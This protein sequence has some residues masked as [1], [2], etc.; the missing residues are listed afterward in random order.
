M[1]RK[2]VH[3]KKLS[4]LSKEQEQPLFN[5]Q[6]T[7]VTCDL[8]KQPPGYVLDTLSLGPKNA[9]LDRFNPK[10]ILAELDD[11]L[12]FCK[13]NSVQNDT[14]TDINIKTLTYIK[15]CKKMK[16]PRHLMLTRKYLN[17]NKLL[18]VPFDKGIGFCIMKMDKYQE[19]GSTANLEASKKTKKGRRKK[20]SGQTYCA[21]KVKTELIL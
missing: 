17:D 18:A 15:K 21:R 2:A 14:I 4:N 3:E 20:T 1:E 9:T 8:E 13:R 10:D 11:L 12:R 16:T 6:N 7:V 19:K 5:V